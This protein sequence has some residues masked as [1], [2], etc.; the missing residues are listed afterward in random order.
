L[1]GLESSDGHSWA[2]RLQQ[3]GCRVIVIKRG[4]SGQTVVDGRTGEAWQI[5]AYPVQV[6]DITG[7]GHAYC[8]GFLAGWEATSD[9]LEAGLRGAVSA[10]LAV[11]GIGPMYPLEAMPGLAQARL[12][13]LRPRARRL[14]AWT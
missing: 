2:H 7:A 8:G 3:S 4:A 5:P 12:E 6:R 1:L 14:Q 9:V 11:E 13:A 10:S